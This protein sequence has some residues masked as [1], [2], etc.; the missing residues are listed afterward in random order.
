MR[1]H[2]EKRKRCK[3][4]WNIVLD[5]GYDPNTGMRDRKCRAFRGTKKE[6]DVQAT[7]LQHRANT[8][9]LVLP[10][11]MPTAAFL[12]RWLSDC[13]QITVNSSTYD[14]YSR[15]VQNRLIP[16]I[17]ATP[18][19]SLTPERIQ[20]LY[21]DWLDHGRVDGKGGLSAATVQRYHQCLHTAL[22]TAVEWKLV[23][24]NVADAVKVPRSKSTGM[25]ILD[26]DDLRRLLQAA[27]DTD[28]YSVFHFAAFTGMRRSEILAVRWCDVDLETRKV[29][30]NQSLHQLRGGEFEI[31]KVKTAYSKRCIELP[32]STALVLRQHREIAEAACSTVGRTMKDDDLVFSRADG[33]PVPPD[34]VTKRWIKLVRAEGLFGVRFHDLRHTHATLLLKWGVHPKI[35]Q[36]RLGH[37]SIRTTLDIY[38]HVVPGLQQAAADIFDRRLS[39]YGGD[40]LLVGAISELEHKW[41]LN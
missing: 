39:G 32:L 6:A 17:G 38:S 8:G 33:Q 22:D 31:R 1:V 20:R 30:V 23:G 41:L 18:L 26:E 14:G 3:N 34:A 10:T 15:I 5:Y 35:V 12:D 24:V 9:G 28:Y 29:Y 16:T 27:K 13:C 36:E 11:K 7:E 21:A 19:P 37:S 2:V 25:K 4:S 40:G